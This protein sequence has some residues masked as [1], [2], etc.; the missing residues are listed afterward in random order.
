MELDHLMEVFG[1]RSFIS[2]WLEDCACWFGGL[3]K[4]ACLVDHFLAALLMVMEHAISFWCGFGILL[5]WW[6]VLGS[7]LGAS[8][9][10]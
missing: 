7:N 8:S 9:L 10:L 3:L 2:P 1:W 5:H 6:C 4:C